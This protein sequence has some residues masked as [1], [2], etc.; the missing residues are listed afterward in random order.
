MLAPPPKVLSSTDAFAGCLALGL[1]FVGSLYVGRPSVGRAPLP[2]SHPS[3][4]RHRIKAVICVSFVAPAVPLGLLYVRGAFANARTAEEALR[5]ALP[6]FGLARSNA[7]I[8]I[9]AAPVAKA[10]SL[11]LGPLVEAL[12]DSSRGVLS[13]LPRELLPSKAPDLLFVRNCVVAPIAEEWVFRANI[14]PLFLA[15]G[16]SRAAIVAIVPL[17]FGIAHLHHLLEAFRAQSV[18]GERT[19]VIL[20]Q[21]GFQFGYTTVFGCWSTYWL[22]RTGNI[23]AIICCHAICNYMG[24]PQVAISG[25]ETPLWKKAL[26]AASYLVGMVSFF[27]A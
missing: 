12:L 7:S 6:W 20:A 13:V 16:F 3:V 8:W 11:Y 1:S 21:T 10:A 27:S 14:I 17:F 5:M 19:S 23:G 22:L 24:F 4:I 26:L 25:T 15:A 18:T 9:V 2:R